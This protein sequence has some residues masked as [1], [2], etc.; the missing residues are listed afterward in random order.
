MIVSS[1]TKRRPCY[2]HGFVEPPK[3]HIS[4]Y[5]PQKNI[6]MPLKKVSVSITII[7]NICQIQFTHE[8]IN[9]SKY[10]LECQYNFPI[11][12]EWAVSSFTIQIDDKIIESKIFEAEVADQ[13]FSTQ[14]AQGNSAFKMGYSEDN[15]SCR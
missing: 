8:Y 11:D 14:I 10:N 3:P 7:E 2:T 12:S 4:L 13:K 6:P 15:P 5:S 1:L 9:S